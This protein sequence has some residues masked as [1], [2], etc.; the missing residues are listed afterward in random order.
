MPMTQG[1]IILWLL[2]LLVW[3]PIAGAEEGRSYT[4]PPPGD[5]SIN[6]RQGRGDTG[7]EFDLH[8]GVRGEKP[9]RAGGRQETRRSGRAISQPPVY[10]GDFP[11]LVPSSDGRYCIAVERREFSTPEGATAYE[12][13]Q[14]Q[15]WMRL[16]RTYDLCP[17]AVPPAR[18]PAAQ[19]ASYWRQV[20]ED[21][22]PRPKPYIAPGFML[23]GKVGYLELGSPLEAQ[24]EHPTPLGLLKVHARSDVFVDWGDG[25]GLQGPYRGPSGPWPNGNI[26]YSWPDARRYDV[27]VVQRWVATWELAGAS[28]EVANLATEGTLE[29]FEVRQLQAVRNL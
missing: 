11:A 2:P 4:A 12:M 19:A 25:K 9:T 14:E 21:L 5:H 28:D 13:S 10:Y 24:F 27:K 22:L 16:A 18:S 8:G 26:T 29:D 6:V 15:R 7:V 1:L 23:A 17:G 3:P 20:G